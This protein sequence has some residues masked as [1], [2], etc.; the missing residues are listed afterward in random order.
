MVK[1]YNKLFCNSTRVEWD[2]SFQTFPGLDL[3]ALGIKE[4]YKSQKNCI[5]MLKSLG[6]GIV[7]HEVGL[8]KTLIMAI[9]AQEMKRLKLAHKPLLLAL[10]NNIDQVVDTCKLA[11]PKA[12]ILYTTKKEFTPKG[13]IELFNKIKNNNWDLVIL[14]HDQFAKIPQSLDIQKEII[15]EELEN[16]RLNLEVLRSKG[17]SISKKLELN[18][19]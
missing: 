6:G 13:R 2:G 8:G 9:A 11:Y 16:V 18:R 1:Q 15:E 5:W 14:S 4:L 19:L 3:K 12:K 17:I 7:H 10:P